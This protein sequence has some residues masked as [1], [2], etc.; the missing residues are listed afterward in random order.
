MLE[1]T[2]P[3]SIRKKGGGKLR[4]MKM[5]A[6][7]DLVADDGFGDGIKISGYSG[8]SKIN[9]E[10][11]S[12]RARMAVTKAQ[13]IAQQGQNS[14]FIKTITSTNIDLIE[15]IRSM[16]AKVKNED[17]NTIENLKVVTNALKVLTEAQA[18][19][20]LLNEDKATSR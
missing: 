1:N 3:K 14:E 18:T 19:F 8:N 6:V 2:V 11:S 9:R 5:V 7:P 20:R 17:T 12:D 10:N 13:S 15:S 16:V 4:L